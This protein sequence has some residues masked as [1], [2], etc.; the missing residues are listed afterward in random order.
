MIGKKYK[1]LTFAAAV[2][3]GSAFW[4]NHWHYETYRWPREIQKS[5]LNGNYIEFAQN[6]TKDS[7]ISYGEGF[8]RWVY[9]LKDADNVQMI[10]GN[11]ELRTCQFERTIS[12]D[13][14][15]VRSVRL[16]NMNLVVEEVWR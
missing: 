1:I 14:G 8:H 16:S 12:I 2:T 3:V 6:G 7:V 5:V 9:H 13:D 4:I 11:S 15:V 10:C